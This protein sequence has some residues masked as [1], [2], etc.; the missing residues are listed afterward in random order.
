MT[1]EE[2]IQTSLVASLDK[3][4]QDKHKLAYN[5]INELIYRTVPMHDA[6]ERD[7]LAKAL[8]DSK[9]LTHIL[10][11]QSTVGGFLDE[12]ALV[13]RVLHDLVTLG[14]PVHPVYTDIANKGLDTVTRIKTELKKELI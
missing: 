1:K 5:H 10:F 6:G 2:E 11:N 4:K 9:E 3:Y 14:K 7:R 12:V 13:F 8:L